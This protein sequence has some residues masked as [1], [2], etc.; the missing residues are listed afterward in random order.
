MTGSI[1]VTGAGG[2]IGA[3]TLRQL[4][5]DNQ[6]VVAFDLSG[7]TRRAALLM[8][9]DQMRSVQWEQGDIADVDNMKKV[10]ERHSVEAII[11]L[12]ALQVPFCKADPMNGARV[13]VLGTVNVFEAAREFG[14]ERLTYASSVAS[15]GM[16][17]SPWLKTLY[18]AYKMCDENLAEVYWQDWQV[19]SIGIRP[20]VIYGVARD[21]GMTSLPTLAIL[22]GVLGK[23][24]EVTFTGTVGFIYAQEA[25]M[26]FIAAVSNPQQEAHVYDLNGT[27]ATV[28]QVLDIISREC[29]GASLTCSGDPLPFPGELSDDPLRQ[30]IAQYPSWTIE[31]GVLETVERFRQLV[32]RGALDESDLLPGKG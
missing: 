7:D 28:Q 22:A 23:P 1:L 24:F 2:C 32:A 26:A 20:V 12:A 4:V 13:N 11:H 17:D 10:M 6:Q 31:R 15:H 18:G 8:T 29:P 3:W 25:A 16:G 30:A 14:I 21:Q 27:P 9:E 5:A 19:P